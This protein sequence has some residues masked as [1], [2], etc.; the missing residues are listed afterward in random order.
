MRS[1]LGAVLSRPKPAASPTN[2]APANMD[3]PV[4]MTGRTSG[5]IF[6]SQLRQAGAMQALSAMDAAGV[7]FGIVDRLATSVSLVDWKLWKKAKS[8]KDE[9]RVEVTSHAALDLLNEPNRFYSRQELFEAGQQHQDLTGETWLVI[10]R[11]SR[12]S[13][14]LELW[15]IRPDRM[16][17]VPDAEKFL[18]GY[19]YRSP[20]GEPI[21]LLPTDVVFIRRPDPNNHYRGLGPIRSV[22][23]DIDSTR[24]SMEW[25]RNFFLNSAEPGGIIEVPKTLSENEFNSLRE[26][27]G[28]QH[29]GVANAH[30]VALLEH[31]KWVERSISQ[32]DM[33]FTELRGVTE[34]GIKQAY[35][36]PK[37]ALGEVD[38]VN[39]AQGEASIAMYGKWLLVPRLE[40]WKGA[41]NRRLLPQ[42]GS[43]AQGLEFD[44]VSPVSEDTETENASRTSRVD[45]AVKIIGVGGKKKETLAAFDLPDIPFEDPPPAPAAIPGQVPPNGAVPGQ[46]PDPLQAL[47]APPLPRAQAPTD[48]PE[49]AQVQE[50]WEQ[51]LT[52]LVVAYGPVSA[53]Q[54]AALV[55]AATAAAA[56]VAALAALSVPT[57]AAADV[58]AAA[59]EDLGFVSGRRIAAVLAGQGAPS[60]EPVIAEPEQIEATAA[61]AAALLGAGLSQVASRAAVSA[62]RPGV[63]PAEVA[64]AVSS[65]LGGLSDRSLRD[66]LGG[67]LT[68][69]Q[70]EARLLTA[71]EVEVAAGGS[72]GVPGDPVPPV[73]DDGYVPQIIYSSSEVNDRNTCPP[74]HDVDGEVYESWIAAWV[75]YG[76]GK[77]RGCL[78]RDRCRG[79]VKATWNP[80][81]GP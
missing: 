6:S 73:G 48:D 69:A 70:N 31:G 50:D 42:F 76:G 2:A 77:Y 37:F 43:T 45:A 52:A 54:Q 46:K 74:C 27:W 72:P 16:E 44:Y 41:L 20:D 14:P 38:D 39:R 30:R 57:A 75:D 65:A 40:R 28:E 49:L 56:D 59:L 33:Q 9:D 55:A 23:A 8:G 71:R 4:P 51:A 17:P 12:S 68:R 5:G 62:Y 47:L 24:Y 10:G 66:Q 29:K 18:L 21:P 60:V 61:A 36:F 78:G 7:V 67:A 25:N 13:I 81:A 26:R 53:A 1:F 35:G 32:R 64:A 80:Q 58:I 11:S 15:P 79:T 34:A 3:T 22:Q 63:E 19:V